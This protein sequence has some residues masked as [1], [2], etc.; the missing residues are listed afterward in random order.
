LFESP[1]TRA[2]SSAGGGVHS[3]HYPKVVD[4]D[5]PQTQPV[6]PKRAIGHSRGMTDWIFGWGPWILTGSEC[7]IE[8]IG[9]S[10]YK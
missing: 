1:G 3:V 8:P 9:D 7:P 2:R 10:R 4:S 6:K 5:S